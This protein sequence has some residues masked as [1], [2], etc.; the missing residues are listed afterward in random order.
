MIQQRCCVQHNT[1]RCKDKASRFV[2]IEGCK[3]WLC[4][5]HYAINHELQPAVIN[6][7]MT[8]LVASEPIGKGATA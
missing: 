1:W 7:Q 6:Q 4:K 2:T 3:L 5:D 8:M